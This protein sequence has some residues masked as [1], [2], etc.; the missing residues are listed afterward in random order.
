ML[1]FSKESSLL[2]KSSLSCCPLFSMTGMD[3]SPLLL[4]WETV[5]EFWLLVDDDQ[6]F[7]FL[8]SSGPGE[9]R[10]RRPFVS[11]DWSVPV[12]RWWGEELG[13]D[14]AGGVRAPCCEVSKIDPWFFISPGKQSRL[15]SAC[16]DRLRRAVPLLARLWARSVWLN[17]L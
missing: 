10:S 7:F 17:F 13:L 9:R 3:K 14:N 16:W 1:S 12:W 6:P 15:V 4:S 11:F 5:T 8:K 2:C